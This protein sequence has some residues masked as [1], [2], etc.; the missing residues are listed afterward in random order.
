MDMNACNCCTGIT[1]ETP[2]GKFNRPGLPAI[3]YRAGAYAGFKASL[4]ARLSSSDFP[5]LAALTTRSDDD[6]TIALCDALAVLGDVLTFYQERIANES[7]LRTAIERISI[8]ELARLIGYRPSPGVA[9]STWLAFTLQAAPGQ[10]AMASQPSVISV[11]T[12]VQSTPDPGQTPQTFE[13]IAAIT[14]RVEWNAIAAQ[15][16]VPIREFNGLK[17]LYVAGVATQLQ[18]GDAIAIVGTERTTSAASER[19]DVRWVETVT[20]DTTRN[21]TRLTWSKP[22]G[23]VWSLAS[24]QGTQIFAF[25][26]RAAL[27]GNN[28]PDPRLMNIT[29]TD[30]VSNKK[31]VGY[32]IDTTGTKLDLDSTYPKIVAQSWI[33]LAGGYDPGGALEGYVELY[34]VTAATQLS[35][36]NFGLSGKITRLSL[37]STSNLSKFDLQNTQVLAQSEL[38]TLAAKPLLYPVY[39]NALELSPSQAGLAPSQ[40]IAISGKLQ[41]VVIGPVATGISFDNPARKA[42]AGDSFIVLRA[43]EQMVGGAPQALTP[44]Q[45]DPLQLP[46]GTLIWHLQ[47]RDGTTVAVTAPAAALQLQSALATD[48]LVS[49][50]GVIVA[51]ADG[52]TSDIDTTTVTLTAP[53]ANC[54]DRATVTANA[55][56]A[57][58]THG[59]TVSQVGGGGNAAVPN[60]S[61]ALKQSP[62]TYVLDP[63]NPDGRSATLTARV[64]GVQWHE[65]STLYG[66]VASDH[67]YQLSQDNDG[68]T[69]V[70][71]GDGVNGARLP[72]GQNNVTFSYRQGLGTVGNLRGGQL[73]MLLTRP[74]GVTGVTNPA[75]AT[76]GQDPETLDDARGNAPLQVLTLGRV[77]STEDYADFARTFAGIAKAI[78][79]W[80]NDGLARGIYVTIAGPNGGTFAADDPT[81]VALSASLRRFGDALLPLSVQSYR[82]ATFM[83]KARVKVSEDYDADAVL[84]AVEGTLRSAYAFANRDFGEPVSIDDVYATIQNVPGVVASNILALYRSDTG[85]SAS[86]PQPRLLAAMPQIQG[87]TVSAAE[88]LTLDSAPLDLGAMT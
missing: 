51:G 43:P 40:A 8:V 25:R 57:P 82:A 18:P 44:E 53:L 45:L 36:T 28:A 50:V 83:L 70:Q 9:A 2:V 59:L 21:L 60:Q 76:G 68:V 56:V 42:R 13:T 23:G 79:V 87:A 81:P 10:P 5:A 78:S 29:D 66:A 20:T 46:S 34:G 84:A 71:F 12:R 1:A 75:S 65:D 4:L 38:L 49:E 72:T 35:R 14:G 33:A 39:G 54:Y 3:A 17:D 86:E 74:L 52:V 62:L 22:L 27:F 16:T 88:L 6:Y 63:S 32:S 31:W 55:N 7:Y 47:D 64:N 41:R 58:A 69:T 61:F 77:V 85:P 26:Q 30:V 67:V 15:T 11:G 48:L 73:S 37:D 80:I 24:T 19:W